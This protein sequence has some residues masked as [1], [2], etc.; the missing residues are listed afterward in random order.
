MRSAKVSAAALLALGAGA[1][2]WLWRNPQTREQAQRLVGEARTRLRETNIPDRLDQWRGATFRGLANQV[3]GTED[4]PGVLDLADENLTTTQRVRTNLGREPAL[5][6]LPH[7]NVN[8]EGHGIVYL[9]GYVHSEEQR[10]VAE[11]V[12]A[13]TE[14]VGQVVN[15]LN[16]EQAVNL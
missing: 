4:V 1:A 3:P 15:E 5:A 12:A 6:D 11:T 2:L 13:N 8:T 7:L 14:G 9:R 16:I 10:R